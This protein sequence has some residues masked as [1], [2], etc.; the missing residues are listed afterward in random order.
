MVKEK[1]KE[2][3]DQRLIDTTLDD[4]GHRQKRIQKMTDAYSRRR[5]ASHFSDPLL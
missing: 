4:H 5:E 1:D 3:R 2:K